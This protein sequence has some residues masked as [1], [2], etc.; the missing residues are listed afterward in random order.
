M[1]EGQNH[2]RMLNNLWEHRTVR[3]GENGED[4]PRDKDLAPA[5]NSG[6]CKFY[7]HHEETHSKSNYQRS[8]K[9]YFNEI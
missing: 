7:P 8:P 1:N 2:E 3:R 4:K 6:N 5:P 9:K